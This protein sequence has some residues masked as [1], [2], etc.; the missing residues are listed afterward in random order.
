MAA[1]GGVVDLTYGIR[2]NYDDNMMQTCLIRN[3]GIND[4]EEKKHGR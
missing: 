1:S 4:K 3:K 2:Y